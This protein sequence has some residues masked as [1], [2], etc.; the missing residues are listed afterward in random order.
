MHH[1]QEEE[2]SSLMGGASPRKRIA[3]YIGIGIFVAWNILI[4][5]L[6]VVA[7]AKANN[8]DS[9]RGSSGSSYTYAPISRSFTVAK[10]QN[11]GATT[12]VSLDADGQIRVGGGT[13]VYLNTGKPLGL[14]TNSTDMKV[15]SFNPD[16]G[17]NSLVSTELLLLAYSSGGNSYVQ[18]GHVYLGTNKLSSWGPAQMI[19][20]LPRVESVI[21]LQVLTVSKLSFAVAGNGKIYVGTVTGETTVAI[22]KAIDFVDASLNPDNTRAQLVRLSANTFALSFYMIA[23]SGGAHVNNCTHGT[24]TFNDAGDYVSTELATPIEFQTNLP[25]STIFRLGTSVFGLAYPAV[26]AVT[27]N[28]TELANDSLVVRKV[29]Y[30]SST[31]SLTLGGPA[32]LENAKPNYYMTSVGLPGT[33]GERAV[34]TF[35]DAA[36][37]NA[38]TAVVVTV[39]LDNGGMIGLNELRFGDMKR[40]SGDAAGSDVWQRH[41]NE[42]VPF[43]S[44][45]HLSDHDIAIA[46]SD[47]SNDGRITTFRLVVDPDTLMIN[48]QG[49]RFVISG[50]LPSA[51]ADYWWVAAVTLGNYDQ[52]GWLVMQYLQSGSGL[53]F[54]NLNQTVVEVA[55]PPFGIVASH[56]KLAKAG[57]STEVVL[58]GVYKLADA[59]FTPGRYYYANTRG[60]LVTRAGS[61]ASVDYVKEANGNLVSMRSRI[62]VAISKDELLLINELAEDNGIEF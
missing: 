5:I 56:A 15:I 11:I 41:N 55:P 6:A 17:I 25:Y 46:Y 40:L 14:P 2:G 57:E 28:S 9:G 51:A 38:L 4:F 47:F 3:L 45:S 58:S 18:V 32:R 26:P 12:P 54:P 22:S 31:K 27:L 62:G 10:G 24:V 1:V 20:N 50:P 8:V 23:M 7:I 49:T 39:P 35:I 53:S 19:A 52:E 60:E 30:S 59:N 29:V 42:V 37:G 21:P 43:I 44:T 34:I 36:A 16:T 33:L 13:S 48:A 61:V